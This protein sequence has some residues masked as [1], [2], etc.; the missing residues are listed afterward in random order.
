MF[1][2]CSS[3]LFLTNYYCYEYEEENNNTK[4]ITQSHKCR[5]CRLYDKNGK[6]KTSLCLTNSYSVKKKK[7]FSYKH[8]L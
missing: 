1:L 3:F 6:T 8:K 7:T 2:M 4:I 5:N